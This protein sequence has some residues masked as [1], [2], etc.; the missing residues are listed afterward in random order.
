M[1][2]CLPRPGSRSAKRLFRTADIFFAG[3]LLAVLLPSPVAAR[4]DSASLVFRKTAGLQK[5]KVYVVKKGEWI[6]G[7]LRTQLG[8]EPVPYALIRK[9]NP[10]IRNLNR[11]YPG[12][13]ILLPVRGMTDA[14]EPVRCW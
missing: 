7:I 13:K 3:L 6:A 4:E 12:Q 11:I 10:K 9:I 8:D 2:Q 1:P 14:T 5:T